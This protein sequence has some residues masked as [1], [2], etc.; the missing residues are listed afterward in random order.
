M[1]GLDFVHGVL[2]KEKT[3]LVP[4]ESQ[5]QCPQQTNSMAFNL[6][7]FVVNSHKKYQKMQL[8]LGG[9]LKKITFLRRH[10]TEFNS[11]IRFHMVSP[12]GRCI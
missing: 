1:S 10:T 12:S 4:K 9:G 6:Y 8:F 11:P 5:K 3:S 7:I 2:S